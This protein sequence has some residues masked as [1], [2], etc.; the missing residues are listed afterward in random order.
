MFNEPVDAEFQD[1]LFYPDGT[2]STA[3]VTIKN[4][5]GKY[6]TIKLR[7]LTGAARVTNWFTVE[8]APR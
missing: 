7:G 2:T 6:I 1:I 5:R 4:E 3:E 8:E